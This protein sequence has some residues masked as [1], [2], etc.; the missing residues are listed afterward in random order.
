MSEQKRPPVPTIPLWDQ[1]K[2]LLGRKLALHLW[3]DKGKPNKP[4]K[5]LMWLQYK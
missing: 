4:K 1:N 5:V 2:S 3:E